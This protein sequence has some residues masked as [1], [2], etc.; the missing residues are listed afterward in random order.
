[1]LDPSLLF[2]C[3][4]LAGLPKGFT[5]L[6]EKDI[7]QEQFAVD[8]FKQV[9]IFLMK[10]E[11]TEGQSL[12][13]KS[14]QSYVNSQLLLEVIKDNKVTTLYQNQKRSVDGKQNLSQ[15][16]SSSLFH[17]VHLR[18]KLRGLNVL[19]VP[20]SINYERIIESAYVTNEIS[21][22]KPQVNSM[23]Q[24]RDLMTSLQQGRMGK[25][26]IKYLAPISY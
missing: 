14:I 7:Y 19:L 3:N 11:R 2:F 24:F 10:N 1:M 5:F 17:L 8:C 25:V 23:D 12:Q 20:V 26:I 6:N 13:A 16:P 22:D 9:G 15:L 18:E 21:S 4:R